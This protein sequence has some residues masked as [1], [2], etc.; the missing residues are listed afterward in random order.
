[1]KLI[2]LVNRQYASGPVSNSNLLVGMGISLLNAKD[3]LEAAEILL[4]ADKKGAALSHFVIAAEEVGKIVIYGRSVR[5]DDYERGIAWAQSRKDLT[6]HKAK[7]R[8]FIDGVKYLTDPGSR[9]KSWSIGLKLTTESK[10]FDAI[11]S[12]IM[13]TLKGKDI[14]ILLHFARLDVTYSVITERGVVSPLRVANGLDSH[15]MMAVIR[16]AQLAVTSFLGLLNLFEP[17]PNLLGSLF[18]AASDNDERASEKELV[19][20]LERWMPSAAILF[21]GLVRNQTKCDISEISIREI[22]DL[23]AARKLEIDYKF[24]LEESFNIASGTDNLIELVEKLK[25]DQI[26]GAN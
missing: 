8:A 2:S 25:S 17:L 24:L 6:D 23:L 12:G 11:I 13:K 20:I 26:P 21:L 22:L 14:E 19:R 3:H 18:N 10:E 5:L 7:I 1:M 15:Q 9:S 16:L 4:K